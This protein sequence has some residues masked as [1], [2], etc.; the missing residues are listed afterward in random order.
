MHR[1]VFIAWIAVL[2]LGCIGCKK[3]EPRP[4][5]GVPADLAQKVEAKIKGVAPKFKVTVTD[6]ATLKVKTDLDLEATISL[7]NLKLAC[8]SDPPACPEMTDNFVEK[9]VSSLKAAQGPAELKPEMIRAVLKNQEYMDGLKEVYKQSPP[10]KREDNKVVSKKFMSGLY[11]V[12]VIDSPGSMRQLSVGDMKEMKLNP[13]KVHALALAN[14]EKALGEIPKADAPELPGLFVVTAG[15]SYEA[16]R[17]LLHKQWEKIAKEIEGDLI[18][19]IPTR[20]LVFFTG[21]A[22]ENRVRIL[23]EMAKRV[24]EREPYSLTD[25]LFKWTPAGWVEFSL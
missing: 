16:A 9:I 1:V 21:S 24:V 7:D 3:E 2:A 23:F 22:D 6:P 12:Y 10:E 25:K 8:Q 20:D 19:A 18:V 13:E 14:M 15:D 4:A 11:I 17:F 5:P